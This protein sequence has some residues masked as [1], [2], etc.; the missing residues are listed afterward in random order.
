MRREIAKDGL[1]SEV[2]NLSRINGRFC[3]AATRRDLRLATSVVRVSPPHIASG[4]F[5]LS[6]ETSW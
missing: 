2:L 1:C 3:M 6:A 4:V 5:G